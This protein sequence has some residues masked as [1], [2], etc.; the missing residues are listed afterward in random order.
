MT[1][2]AHAATWTIAKCLWTIHW[3]GHSSGMQNAL[4]AVLATPNWALNYV[5]NRGDKGS[6]CLG[7]LAALNGN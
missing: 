2:F 5:F 4:S 6:H 1:V 3:A 7:L